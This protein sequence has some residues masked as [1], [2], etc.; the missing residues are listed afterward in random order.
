MWD[1]PVIGPG[2]AVD[3]RLLVGMFDFGSGKGGQIPA[4]DRRGGVTEWLCKELQLISGMWSS[5][6]HVTYART[7][8][9]SVGRRG[10]RLHCDEST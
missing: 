3:S 10:G 4:R 5:I 8:C 6:E 2:R 9:P 1:S 7:K